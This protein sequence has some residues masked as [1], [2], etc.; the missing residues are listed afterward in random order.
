MDL[1]ISGNMVNDQGN[2]EVFEFGS[3]AVKKR[4]DVSDETANIQLNKNIRVNK[5]IFR[6]SNNYLH[7]DD[8]SSFT[9]MRLDMIGENVFTYFM[10]PYEDIVTAVKTSD[11]LLF[12]LIDEDVFQEYIFS[13]S[14]DQLLN[15]QVNFKHRMNDI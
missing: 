5:C 2:E 1:I 10:R 9:V 3:I 11:E 14:F 7:P 12:V 15:Y 13:T 8:I 4:Q 6:R